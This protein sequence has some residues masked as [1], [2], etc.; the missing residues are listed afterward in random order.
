MFLFQILFTDKTN[1][2]IFYT[3]NAGINITAALVGFAPSDVSINRRN[4]Q[5]I[6]ASQQY[7]DN[8]KTRTKVRLEERV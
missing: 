7:L 1:Q 4:P 2:M 5:F 6:V 8:G 3:T